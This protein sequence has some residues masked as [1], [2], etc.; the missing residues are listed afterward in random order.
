MREKR[1]GG[2]LV[3]VKFV[4]STYRTSL[5]CAA[6]AH[7][8]QN[9]RHPNLIRFLDT[10]PLPS[11]RRKSGDR[12]SGGKKTSGCCIVMEFCSGGDLRAYL[13]RTTHHARVA[14]Q[15]KA[16]PPPPPPRTEGMIWFWFLQLCLGLH[17]MH[18]LQILHRDVKTANIF[19]SNAGFLV[20]GDFGIARELRD[21]M[22]STVV[23]T[24]LYMAPETLDGKP[25]SFASDIW[26]LGCV[27]YEI[28]T[29]APPFV[30]AT[31]P[32]LIRKI[33]DG[34]FAPL[35]RSRFSLRLQ[36]TVAAMLRTDASA[37]P[38]AASILR[39]ASMHAHLKRYFYD[40]CV[41]SRTVSRHIDNS[42]RVKANQEELA[43]LTRQLQSLGV[44]VTSLASCEPSQELLQP[45][46]SA[47]SAVDSTKPAVAIKNLSEAKLGAEREH[48][49]RQQLL[50]ALDNLQRLRQHN[51][52]AQAAARREERNADRHASLHFAPD[53]RDLLQPQS[54]QRDAVESVPREPG[55]VVFPDFRCSGADSTHEVCWHDP[56]QRSRPGSSNRSESKCLDDMARKRSSGSATLA[57]FLGIPRKGVPLT[58]HAK[59]FVSR[60]PICKD[61]RL[62]RKTERAK[63]AAKYKERLASISPSPPSAASTSAHSHASKPQRTESTIADRDTDEDSKRTRDAIADSIAL[64]EDALRALAH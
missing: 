1:P 46:T 55:G 61:V 35:P 53:S 11:A 42:D 33:C 25:Y 26:S 2:R 45:A 14:G 48:E 21:E 16:P 36:D 44:V 38:T 5:S 22:A 4:Q 37:R 52:D 31:T 56:V 24:P 19:L 15:A 3:C 43:T 58:A 60:S 50:E 10:F 20:L 13:Q 62:L 32:G 63:A 8:M 54:A 29:G 28:C 30:A 39:D 64:L 7:L 49:R 40:R 9:L 27:L 17:H 12:V 34:K 47:S 59:E 18:E 23:G 51:S 6:E 57:S 41:A